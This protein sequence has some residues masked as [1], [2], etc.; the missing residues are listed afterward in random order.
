M[1]PFDLL[2]EIAQ[3]SRDN[4]NELPQ[5]TEA[6]TF[7]RGIGFMLAGQKFLA[8][9]GQVGEILQTPRV[10]KVPGVRNW[11]LGVANI[12]GRLV[13]IL[14]LAGFLDV[15]SKANWRTRRVLVVGEGQQ[16]H[17]LLVDDVLG[18]QQF[19]SHEIIN[20][21]YVE[22]NYAPYVRGGFERDGSNW[23]IFSFTDLVQADEFLQVAV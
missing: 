5:K 16:Q 2:V 18:M 23:P 15:P 22:A 21:M 3:K 8:P 12:R 19:P 1:S 14:D 6:V 13:P 17:G 9:M 7:W 10:T 11:M 4:A 20:Q